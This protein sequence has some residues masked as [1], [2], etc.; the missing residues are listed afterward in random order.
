MK[1]PKGIYI[2]LDLELIED[3]KKFK[4]EKGVTIREQVSEGLKLYHK[5]NK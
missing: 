1:K 2:E 4:K 3:T 5:L